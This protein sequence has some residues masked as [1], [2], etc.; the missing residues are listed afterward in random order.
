MM[1]GFG[2][3][4]AYESR[5]CRNPQSAAE[6][7]GDLKIS[8]A[9]LLALRA[10]RHAVDDGAGRAFVGPATP[11]KLPS[12]DSL[13]SEISMQTIKASK[14]EQ[15]SII[16]RDR[17]IRSASTKILIY[18][19]EALDT[20]RSPPAPKNSSRQHWLQNNSSGLR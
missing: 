3:P 7:Y 10:A 13:S 14:Q 12:F 11:K 16:E 18:A 20:A 2:C 1:K 5:P 4:E 6:R 15:P 8:A 19:T 17:L 9:A